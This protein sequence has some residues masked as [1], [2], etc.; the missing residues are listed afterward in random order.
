MKK[1]KEKSPRTGT[2]NIYRL[3]DPIIHTLWSS[4]RTLNWKPYFIFKA[5]IP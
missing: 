1:Q 5:T 3:K 2:R 4:I